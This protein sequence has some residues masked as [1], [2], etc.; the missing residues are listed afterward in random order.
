M[1]SRV[2][3]V[4]DKPENLRVLDGMLG[5]QYQLI[6][7]QSGEEALDQLRKTDVDVI[8]LDIEMPGLDGFETTRLIK[9]M[10]DRK[11]TPVIL[12]SAVFEAD[13]NVKK[14]FSA[15]AVDQLPKPF[16]LRMLRSKIATY[17]SL[18]EKDAIIQEQTEKIKALEGALRER[19]AT[20]A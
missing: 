19:S 4:D 17:A 8:L 9:Q 18:R 1:K 12:L 16:D 2:M 20:P 15:G 7:A 13:P 5:A 11:D 14:G 6:M 3:I 10:P